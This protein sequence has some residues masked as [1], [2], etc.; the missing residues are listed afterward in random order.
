MKIELGTDIENIKRFTNLKD[1]SIFLNSVYT[2]N[3]KQYCFSKKNIEQHL[4]ARFAVKESVIKAFYSMNKKFLNFKNIEVLNNID[5]SPFVNIL[6]ED[7][8]KYCC[9]ISISHS[10]ESAIAFCM[11][12]S[13]D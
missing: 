4:A 11:L 10:K 8:E 12:Y 3:E 5:G 13:L 1:N 7:S 9:K 6:T 2:E